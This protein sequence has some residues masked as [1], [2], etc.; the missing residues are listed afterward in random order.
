MN[1]PVAARRADARS[2]RLP[3]PL[4]EVV[5]FPVAPQPKRRLR[6]YQALGLA[7]LVALACKGLVAGG[8]YALQYS[9][10]LQWSPAVLL[11][12]GRDAYAWWLAGNA[13]GRIIMSQ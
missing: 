9:Q 1:N 4:P 7:L 3:P 10:D 2:P 6:L 8:Y 11:S 5:A 13:D 12:E